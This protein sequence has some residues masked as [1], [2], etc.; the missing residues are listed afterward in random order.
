M[1]VDTYHRLTEVGR[2]FCQEFGILIVSDS[3][4]DGCCAFG[5]ITTLEDA[6]PHENA[7]GSEL[8]HQGGIGRG[9]DTAS[10]EVDDG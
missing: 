6:A 4:H 3:L 8:H 5:R 2:E 7:L 10:G 9:G 1:F